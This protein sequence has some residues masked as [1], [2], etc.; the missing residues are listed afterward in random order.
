MQKKCYTPF[1]LVTNTF[2][3]V[4]MCNLVVW[5]SCCFVVLLFG[6]V[7][8]DLVEEYLLSCCFRTAKGAVS[9]Y[10]VCH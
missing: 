7:F 6:R 1:V 10:H 2:S 4:T 9:K 8:F 3:D 5:L